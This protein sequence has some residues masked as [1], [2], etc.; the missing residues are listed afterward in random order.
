MR[1][2]RFSIWE[3]FAKPVVMFGQPDVAGGRV[4]EYAPSVRRTGMRTPGTLHQGQP[5]TLMG[6]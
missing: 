1:A 4:L 3:R 6:H 5:T 2:G